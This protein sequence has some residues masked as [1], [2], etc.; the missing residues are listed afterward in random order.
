[1]FWPLSAS[2]AMMK[3]MLPRSAPT[4][5]SSSVLSRSARR[6]QSQASADPSAAAATQWRTRRGSM[7]MAS[8]ASPDRMASAAMPKARPRPSPATA[9]ARCA[10]LV[11]SRLTTLPARQKISD[12]TPAT[13]CM[14]KISASSSGAVSRVMAMCGSGP[15]SAPRSVSIASSAAL[16]RTSGRPARCAV[17]STVGTAKRSAM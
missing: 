14:V 6:S 10:A 1:M 13:Q 5:R 3:M 16:E 11:I 4:S 12:M 9:A 2:A 15:D 8:T 17:Q 7:P